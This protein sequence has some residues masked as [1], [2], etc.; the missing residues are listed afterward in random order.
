VLRHSVY[1]GALVLPMS[2]VGVEFEGDQ[3]CVPLSALVA[4]SRMS[5]GEQGQ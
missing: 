3:E 2:E 5:R 1:R 4:I